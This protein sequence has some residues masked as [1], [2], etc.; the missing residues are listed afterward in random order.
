MFYTAS[1]I[2]KYGIILSKGDL[3]V[4]CLNCG[5]DSDNLDYCNNCGNPIFREDK[6]CE[7]C[8]NKIKSS[9]EFAYKQLFELMKLEGDRRE[10]LDSK[11]STYI[12]LLSIAVTIIGGLGGITIATIQNEELLISNIILIISGLYFSTI[13]FF[14]IGVVQAFHA[15]HIGSIIVNENL[16]ETKPNGIN[17]SVFHGMDVDW[18][19]KN[20]DARLQFVEK[21]LIPHI[22]D[23][24][25]I[26][27]Q[28]NNLKS[29]SIIWAYRFSIG[30]I[31]ILLLLCITML[32]SI[33]GVR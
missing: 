22:G 30:G 8:G 14:I 26:N 12:G 7:K 6:Y 24:Y 17:R 10:Q 16:L 31:S 21:D 13:I 29:N 15:Y 1:F 28:L 20:S 11:A 18:L 33:L 23:I 5:K 2:Q 4:L 32:V 27:S 9:R 25:S 19:V 3:I